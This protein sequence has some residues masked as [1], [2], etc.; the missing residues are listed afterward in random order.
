MKKLNALLLLCVL[1]ISGI[2]PASKLQAQNLNVTYRSKMTFPGQILANI[3]GYAANGREYALVGAKRGM[4]I[5]DVTNPDSPVK[6][7]QIPG[8][9]NWWKEIKTYKHYAYVTTEGGEGVQIVDLSKLPSPDLAYKHYKGDGEIEG[10]L[11]TIHALH[12]DTTAGFLYAHGS[13]LFSGGPVILDLADPYNPKYAG[14]YDELGY[15]H[16]GWADNDTLYAGHIGAGFFSVVDMRDKSK[17]VVLGIQHTPNAATHNTWMSKDRNTIFT[18]D[19]VS[20]SYLAAYDIRD[21]QDILLL[22]KIQANPGSAAIVHNTHILENYAVTSW[23]SEGVSIVDVSRPDNL[24]QVGL[25]DVAPG[26]TGG[27][28]VGCWGVY[29]FLPSGNILASVIGGAGNDSNNGELWVL[30]PDYKKACYLEGNVTDADNGAPLSNAV[31][32]ILNGNVDAQE[33]TNPAGVYKTGQANA[34][35]FQ[36]EVSKAGYVTKTVSAVLK[37]GE[38]TVLNVALSAQPTVA[39]TGMVLSNGDNK[40]IPN[41]KVVLLSN[42]LNYETQSGADGA[43]LLPAVSLGKYELRAGAWGYNT[44]SRAN[45]TLSAAQAYTLKL[46]KGYR[47]DFSLDLGWE[48]EGSSETGAWE[49]GE[50]VGISPGGGFILTP[51]NDAAGDIGNECYVTGNDGILDGEDVENGTMNLISPPMD[52]TTYNDPTLRGLLFFTSI[53]FSQNSFDSIKIY[54]SNGTQ[55][56]LLFESA[57]FTFSWQLINKKIKPL[58]PL[59]ANMQMRIECFD[60][61]AITEQDSY[62]AAFDG[63][64]IAEGNPVAT[65]TPELNT[66]FVARANP[67]A[68]QALLEYETPAGGEYQIKIYDLLGRCRETHTVNGTG[69][70]VYTGADLPAGM[71][72]ARLEQNGL[73]NAEIKLLKAG[74]E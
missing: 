57:G 59:T 35:T 11:N 73:S 9:D 37:N 15:V 19:E 27:E 52:L 51:E 45:Q 65:Q 5:V 14:K 36:V 56:A 30:T 69:G 67:F 41:A 50:P 64:R 43:F 20:H 39:V 33:T 42:G 66:R 28:F 48:V 47:D 53:T 4:V 18:T 74:A 62:E 68:N 13:N 60:N 23:Y 70:F 6:I 58:L 71:Y 12:I 63:F 38:L 31:V 7:V 32:T 29:P 46:D 26:Y 16:D 55:E 72:V 3:G 8:P 54:I 49:R 61:P 2:L 17:P 44:I 24:V 10:Q 22:D 21:P 40:P 34:G 25:Y 1:F